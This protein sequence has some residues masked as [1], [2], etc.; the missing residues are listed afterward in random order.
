VAAIFE[1]EADAL[2][3]I[4]KEKEADRF[5]ELCNMISGRFPSLKGWLASRPLTALEYDRQWPRLLSVLTW[6]E[7]YPQPGIYV[8]QLEVPDVD[9]KFIEQ[10]KKLL[11]ELL[12]IILPHNAIDET[13]RG[14]SG[15]EQRYGFLSKPSQIRFRLLD[16][17]LY[18][19]GLSDLQVPADDFSMLNLPV[20]KVF[21]T[22]ND[23]NGL[24]FPSLEKSLVIFGLG[25]GLDRL[26]R[27]DWLADKKLYYWGDIDTHGFAMLD[28][29]RHFFPHTV[30]F[31]M[32]RQTLMAHQSSWVEEKTQMN[33]ELTRLN[34]VEHSLYDDLKNDRLAGG[35]RLEQER[36]SFRHVKK[37][38]E[39]FK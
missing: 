28:Q 25:Y 36:I 37:C 26:A 10:H 34:P 15:F 8:R 31:L 12:D 29:M 35:V 11:A 38:L 27:A 19:Q 1:E 22:E 20:D 24:A 18:I 16:R 30:S 2:A 33:R 23:I 13:A 3:C 21:I 7:H 9:T 6:L 39:N 5:S 17:D 14:I 4:G 32:D